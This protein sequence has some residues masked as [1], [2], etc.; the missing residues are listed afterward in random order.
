[1]SFRCICEK[2]E[3][4]A[5]I[6]EYVLQDDI[7]KYDLIVLNQEYFR[8]DYMDYKYY[9]GIDW[10]VDKE[11]EIWLMYMLMTHL[12]DHRDGFTG[13]SFFVLHYQGRTIEVVLT[14]ISEE[15]STKLADN[16]F[17][18]V[19]QLLCIK[20]EDMLGLCYEEVLGVLEEALKVYGWGGIIDK[21]VQ[22]KL[23]VE[24]RR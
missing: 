4:M 15:S 19:W 3:V 18:V 17:R 23:F 9:M 10:C 16:P 20:E 12:E 7:E 21:E 13:E 14:R 11:R 8:R 5:F 24:L 22:D 1:M 6:N 2:D